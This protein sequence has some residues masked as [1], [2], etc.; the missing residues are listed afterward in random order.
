VCGLGD[1]K[2]AEK[3]IKSKFSEGA[4]IKHPPRYTFSMFSIGGDNPAITYQGLHP[5][6]PTDVTGGCGQAARL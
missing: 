6:T 4:C 5:G 1:L 2:V 3:Q